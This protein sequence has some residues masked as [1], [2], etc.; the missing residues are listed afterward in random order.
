MKFSSHAVLVGTI[1]ASLALSQPLGA[2]SYYIDPVLGSDSDS[3]DSTH[4]KKTIRGLTDTAPTVT[5]LPGDVV[6][7]RGVGPYN[8]PG[9]RGRNV[10]FDGKFSGTSNGVVTVQSDPAGDQQAV[11][12]PGVP[13]F[14]TN[15]ESSWVRC[16]DPGAHP[17]EYISVNAYPALA[18]QIQDGIH[19]A[20]LGTNGQATIRLLSYNRLEDLRATNESFAKVPYDGNDA[21][22]RPIWDDRGNMLRWA[23]RGPGVWLDPV[24]DKVHF[25]ASSTHWNQPGVT[26]Y[27]STPG[28]TAGTDPRTLSMSLSL[29][30]YYSLNVMAD[31]ITFKNIVVQNGGAGSYSALSAGPS[32]SDYNEHVTFDHCFFFLGRN[33]LKV[34]TSKFTKI[35]NSVFDGKLPSWVSRSDVKDDWDFLDYDGVSKGHA[36]TCR[37]TQVCLFQNNLD[38]EDLEIAYSEFRNGHDG[39]QIWGIRTQF[40]HNLLENL[41]DEA[42]MFYGNAPS[43]NTQIYNNV[44]RKTT[45]PL[46]SSQGLDSSS[47][48]RYIYRNIIDGRYPVLSFRQLSPDPVLV[49]RIGEDFKMNT[50][51]PG[52]YCYQ[53]TFIMPK[54]AGNYASVVWSNIDPEHLKPR[55]FLNNI[56]MTIQNDSP[57]Y[58]VPHDPMGPNLSNGNTWHRRITNPTT[59]ELVWYNSPLPATTTTEFATLADFL[60]S[61]VQTAYVTVNGVGWETNSL[62]A[63]PQFIDVPDWSPAD[64]GVFFNADYRIKSTSPSRYTGFGTGGVLLPPPPV[65]GDP[66][67]THWPDTVPYTT[68]PDAGA[69]PYLGGPVAVGVDGSKRFPDGA[70]PTAEAGDYSV[71]ADIDHNGFESIN[72]DASGS[73]TVPG[74]TIKNYSWSYSG[75]GG[76]TAGSFSRNL[77]IGTHDFYLTVTDNNN[78][79]AKDMR[80][81]TVADPTG[82][83]F[84]RNPGLENGAAGWSLE[85]AT[86][87]VSTSPHSGLGAMKLMG[88]NSLDW[89]VQEVSVVPGA[90]IQASVWLK[91]TTLAAGRFAA[92]RLQWRDAQHNPLVDPTVSVSGNV[93]GTSDWTQYE[94]TLRTPSTAAYALLTMAM[95]GWSTGGSAMFDDVRLM[96]VDNK[97]INGFMEK[98]VSMST[99]NL[100]GWKATRGYQ[101]GR[102]ANAIDF[103]PTVSHSGNS[104]LKLTGNPDYAMAEQM[105]PVNP[106]QTYHLEGWIK[107]VG[108]PN[109]TVAKIQVYYYDS[110]GLGSLG[111]Q[112]EPTQGS[113]VDWAKQSKNFTIPT[114]KGVAHIKV[115]V[116]IDSAATGGVAYLDDFYLK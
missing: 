33:G 1:L 110:T 102:P 67:A 99:T 91:T 96:V 109:S 19:G 12:D 11:F 83:D 57:F 68:T 78:R 71:V 100:S 27:A 8:T 80:Q 64:G 115:I 42:I 90:L 77:P 63:Y 14:W 43:V 58:A 84:V 37:E 17:D 66:D 76:S 54:I 4:P 81:V 93:G 3:G 48:T 28:A 106:G 113:T 5:L 74:T 73:G 31:H 32:A 60:S 69:V 116:K 7:L 75:G 10:T 103:D 105:V 70:T 30:P 79:T 86:A 59:P 45:Q 108:M 52:M 65:S 85:G 18:G 112:W 47:D 22:G 56:Y 39:V 21:H 23:Y 6:N 25:R 55:Q 16:T 38:N 111:L 46:S 36:G 87:V 53:N 104:S 24:T 89:A 92:F 62:T 72:F 114:G 41:N 88:Q 51:F 20:I 29:Y 101:P 50:P 26:D 44:I 49:W 61:D 13:D 82:S 34:A 15:P 97:L 2:A 107:T 95:D 94:T 35:T 98:A 9:T 40:H